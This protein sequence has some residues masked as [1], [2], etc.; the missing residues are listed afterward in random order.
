MADVNVHGVHPH[1]F[2]FGNDVLP[3]LAPGTLDRR[4]DEPE[5][6]R[7]VIGEDQEVVLLV[8]D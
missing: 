8:V 4:G 3:R 5:V 1:A 7:A 6:A 2:A